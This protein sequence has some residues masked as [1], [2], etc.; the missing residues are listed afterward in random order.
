[1]SVYH[2]SPLSPPLMSYDTLSRKS[3]PPKSLQANDILKRRKEP[4]DGWLFVTPT[5]IQIRQCVLNKIVYIYTEQ[6]RQDICLYC[7]QNED[8]SDICCVAKE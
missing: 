8:A 6:S 2:T 4:A 3:S 1:M 7:W 5:K